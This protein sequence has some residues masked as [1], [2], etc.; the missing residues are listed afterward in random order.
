MING[1]GIT[2]KKF[3]IT[4]GAGFIGSSL[5]RIISK[6]NEV[7]IF[8]NL[9]NNALKNT[10]L[11]DNPNL[12]IVT[13]NV[14]DYSTLEK[15]MDPDIEYL[16]HCAAIAGVDTVLKN[17]ILTLNVNINGVFNIFKAAG[18][19]TRLKRIIDFSTS[20]I[21]GKHAENVDEKAL[22]LSISPKELRWSYAI[23]KLSGEAI[24]RTYY[25][26]EKMPTVTIRPFN[27]FGPNQ[28]GVGAVHNFVTHAIKELPIIINNNGSQV[29]SWCYI[30]DLVKG[31]L[32]TLENDIAVGQ[33]YNIGNPDNTLTVYELARMIK[34]ISES[35]S[36]IEYRETNY[37]DVELRIPKIDHAYEQ[38]K[39]EPEINME[40]GLKRT[41]EWYKIK[42]GVFH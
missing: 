21:Y 14:L 13:G 2:G 40:E 39:F 17:P 41:I 28:I 38:L 25:I 9:H 1:F 18:K 5:A 31:V 27:I 4:G 11:T 37:P 30:D 36:R 20:E 32:L 22:N 12:R 34:L 8:D 15:S 7:I 16:I 19:L 10:S 23:S 3:L 35:S 6:N 26:H 42:N 33:V 29:R 24:A